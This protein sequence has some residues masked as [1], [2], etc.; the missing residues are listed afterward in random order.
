MVDL[1]RQ[2]QPPNVCVIMSK[3][4]A[5]QVQRRRPFG[6]R[7]IV[8]VQAF[9]PRWLNCS[10]PGYIITVWYSDYLTYMLRQRYPR[11]KVEWIDELE[12]HTY[13][14]LTAGVQDWRRST[15]RRI[16]PYMKID[17]LQKTIV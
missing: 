16:S 10:G 17:I 2:R 11:E 9:R 7:D 4:A 3:P 5:L 13:G 1:M 6:L 15:P 12:V 8:I 14:R